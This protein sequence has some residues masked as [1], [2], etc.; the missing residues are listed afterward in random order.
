MS[1]RRS[2]PLFGDDEDDAPPD[3]YARLKLGE[4]YDPD[5]ADARLAAMVRRE[6]AGP[7]WADVPADVRKAYAELYGT[8]RPPRKKLGPAHRRAVAIAMAG[9][10]AMADVGEDEDVD[11]AERAA[12]EER[13]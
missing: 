4:C 9:G 12:I 3:G 1:R 8:A 11:A 13:P 5:T 2:L 10:P 7:E 6:L